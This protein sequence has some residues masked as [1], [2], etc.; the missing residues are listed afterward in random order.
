MSAADGWTGRTVAQAE[1][2]FT[3]LRERG[4]PVEM[5]RFLKADHNLSRAGSPQQRVARLGAILEWFQRYLA[6]A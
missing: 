3:S 5:L 4:A 2:L 6:L 1:E